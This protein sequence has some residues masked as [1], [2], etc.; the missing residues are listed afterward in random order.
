[1]DRYN[2]Q[3]RNVSHK[4][5]AKNYAP[6]A[7]SQEAEAKKYGLRKK[8]FEAAMLRLFDTGEIRVEPYGPP[9]RGF[10]TLVMR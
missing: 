5:A 2:E 1:V 3:N 10:T 9:S 6:T 7:F 8:D 4:S